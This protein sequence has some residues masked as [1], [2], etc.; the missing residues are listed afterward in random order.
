MTK[1]QP[2]FFAVDVFSG[3]VGKSMLDCSVCHQQH[4]CLK[5]YSPKRFLLAVQGTN[6]ERDLLAGG[7]R[8]VHWPDVYKPKLQLCLRLHAAGWQWSGGFAVDLPG[9]LFVKIRH[10]SAL[11][12]RPLAAAPTQRHGSV[13]RMRKVRL[14]V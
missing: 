10:R 6:I 7:A 4:Q 9:D 3:P 13:L 5:A 1:I 12:Q 2:I 14:W 11:H 8:A